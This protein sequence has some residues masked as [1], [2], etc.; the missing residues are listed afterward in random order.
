MIWTACF[1][2]FTNLCVALAK[3]LMGV[4]SAALYPA[5]VYIA[6]LNAE[7]SAEG[8]RF[9][10]YLC[11]TILVVAAVIVNKLESHRK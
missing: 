5:V 4:I 7:T 8:N 2:G 6:N 1:V 10:L 11:V 3:P 9:C